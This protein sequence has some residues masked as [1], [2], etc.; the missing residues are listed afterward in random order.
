MLSMESKATFTTIPVRATIAAVIAGWL[1][2]NSIEMQRPTEGTRWNGFGLLG[3]K[4]FVR[5][6]L[7]Q[8]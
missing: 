4:L 2:R 8:F 6:K 1:R 3:W 5:V 7:Q